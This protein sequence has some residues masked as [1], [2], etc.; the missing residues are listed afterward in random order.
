MASSLGD[1]PVNYAV[2]GTG[3]AGAAHV[4]ALK[5]AP[6]ARV[7][8]VVASTPERAANAAERLGVSR[9]S[10]SLEEILG[11]DTVDV[12]DNCTP[13]HLHA[14]I[15]RAALEAGKH[16]LSE[17]PLA[18][19]SAETAELVAAAA[20]AGTGTGVCFTYRHFPLVQQTRAMLATRRP[21]MIRGGYLQDW[22]LYEDDWNWRLLTSQAGA[23]RAVGD[24]G[25]HWIDLVGHITGQPVRRGGARARPPAGHR[26]PPGAGGAPLPSGGGGGGPPRRRPQGL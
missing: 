1:S 13:N 23:S 22:L 24:I 20:Q 16:V 15:T 5:R 11:D 19:D 4:M 26:G 10:A 8:A 25:S 9:S 18:M 21:H 2:V 17:K 6:G 7:A 14:S 3:F 12:I